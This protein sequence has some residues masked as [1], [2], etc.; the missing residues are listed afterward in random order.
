[1]AGK[2]DVNPHFY[3]GSTGKSEAYMSPSTGGGSKTEI[4]ARNRQ[5]HGGQLIGQLRRVEAQQ[6]TLAYSGE[7]E[8]PFRRKVNAFLPL[9]IG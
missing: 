6:A 3:L 2:K 8:H 4:P 7:V 5:Q 9:S 1:V